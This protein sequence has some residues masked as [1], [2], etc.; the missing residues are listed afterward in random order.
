RYVFI[1]DKANN[2]VARIRCDVMKTDK[3]I[4]IP[5]AHGIHGLRPQ[6]YPRTGYVFCNGEHIG[7][8]VNDGSNMDNPKENFFSVFTAIDGD[9]MKIAW[10]GMVDRNLD[11]MDADYQGK[12][13]VSTCY[14][15]EKGLNVGEMSANEQ[16]W[17]VVFSLKAIEDAI[18]KGEYEEINGVKV[19]DGRKGSRFTRYVTIPNSPHGCNAAP[20]GI[21]IVLN[22]KLSPT[23][24]VIDVR[25]LDDL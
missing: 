21:H 7:P 18:E 19:V 9:T 14:N 8:M 6:R 12:Y 3:I 24:S 10:Q 20:D 5:N 1:N 13:A 25:K 16:D 15:S 17:A 2:R 22:G 23:C 11:N 4:E